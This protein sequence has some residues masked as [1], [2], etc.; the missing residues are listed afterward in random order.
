[1][2]TFSLRFEYAN[3]HIAASSSLRSR[4]RRKQACP[5]EDEPQKEKQLNPLSPLENPPQTPPCRNI[6]FRALLYAASRP[7]RVQGG[8]K[9]EMRTCVGY[10]C[11]RWPSGLSAYRPPQGFFLWLKREDGQAYA[12]EP[13]TSAGL[14]SRAAA[15]EPASVFGGR[16]VLPIQ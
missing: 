5:K 15:A 1:L 10:S 13:N 12:V 9:G 7:A 8:I 6:E 16:S 4:R 14:S 2:A 11:I 3:E